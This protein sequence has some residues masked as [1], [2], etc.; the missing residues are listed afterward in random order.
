MN[1]VA[2]PDP[3][4]FTWNWIRFSKG[5]NPD[6]GFQMSYTDS[7]FKELDPDPVFPKCGIQIRVSKNP[8]PDP[9]FIIL[10]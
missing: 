4:Y 9:V 3:G 2:D 7:V 10:P 1:W 8:D 6:P 5:L